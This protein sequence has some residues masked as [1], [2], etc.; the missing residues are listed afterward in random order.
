MQYK[1][2][3]SALL[4]AVVSL[5]TFAGF[6]TGLADTAM[7]AGAASANWKFD[8]GGSGAAGGYT[9]VSASDGYNSSRGYGFAQTGN[10]SN[11]SAGGSGAG[12][13]AVKFNNYGTGNTFNVDLPKGLYEIKVMTGNAPRTTIRIEG[14]VQMMNLTG[15]NAVETIRIPVTD[16]Q[17]NVQAIE[18]MSGREQSISAM[19]VTQINTTCEMKPTIWICGDSTVANYYNCADTSQHGWGQFLGNY[20]DSTYWDVR[21]QATSGQYAK[22]FYDG[23][24]F[25]PIET[26]GKPG[27]IYII[28]IGINDSNYSNKDE[29]RQTVTTMVQKAKAKGMTVLLV[30]QQGRRGDLQRSPLLSGRW[31]GGE[32]DTVGSQQDVQVID[33]FTP[34]QNFGL[35]V[36]YDG[37]AS[38]YAIQANGSNDDLHQSKKGAMKLAEIMSTLY[39]FSGSAGAEMNE[40]VYYAFK[41]VNSGLYLNANEANMDVD[42]QKMT[43]PAREM[44]WSLRSAGD[45]YYSINS[46][47]PVMDLEYL[48]EVDGGNGSNGQNVKLGGY[49]EG[50]VTDQLPAYKDSQLF[51]FKRNSDGSYTIL[52]KVSDDKAAVE[53]GSA[54]KDAGANVQ[55]WET[56][57]HACQ[58]WEVEVVNLPLNGNV[59]SDLVIVDSERAGS[60]SIQNSASGM[61]L[62]GDRDFTVSSLPSVLSDSENIVTACDSKNA[63]GD[64]AKF[65]VKKDST[66]YV[67]LDNRVSVPSWMSSYSNTGESFTC[68][69][70]QF[71]IYAKDFAAGEQIVLGSNGTNY[72]CMNYSVFV[73]A[74]PEVTTTTTTEPPVT[75][76][77][78]EAP[79]YTTTPGSRIVMGD[80]NCDGKFSVADAVAILQSI[81]NKDKYE[82]SAQG[83]INGDVDGV[84]GITA[85]DA[86]FLQQVDAGIKELPDAPEQID[87]TASTTTTTTTTTMTTVI[88]PKLYYAVDQTW[89]DGWAESSNGGFTKTE[90]SMGSSQNV[91][92]VNLNNV[93]GSSMTLNVNV[94]TDGNY[95][96]YI[97]YANGTDT[98]RKTNVFV[99]GNTQTYWLQSFPG[100]GSWT[101]WKGI[102][103]VL[104]LKAGANTIK[105]ESAV[106]DGG[107]NFDYIELTFTDEPVAETFDPNAAQQTVD[108]SKPSLFLAGDSTCMYYNASKQSQNG[109]PIQGWGYYL[110]DYFTDDVTVYNNAIAGRSSKKFY[111]EGRFASITENLKKG[112]FVMIQFAI[113]DADYTKEDRYSPV[114]GNV[115]N[116][117][118][119][120]YEWYLTSFIKDT[121]AKGATPILMSCTLSAKSYSDGKFTASYTN[122]TDA[123]KKLAA[124][125]NIPFVDVNGIMVNHY[126]SVGY[127]KAKSYHMA[128]AVAGSSDLTHFNEGGA[129]VISGLIA[130]AV[131]SQSIA[132]LSGYVK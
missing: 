101:D 5:S 102:G 122:Y 88:L 106:S 4:S 76:T 117:Q 62:F 7:T 20:V 115:D 58:K 128:G 83:K 59:V 130:N 49:G 75:T 96:T 70:E 132:G 90:A 77:T 113:N 1:K 12:S 60:W 110:S 30:K 51:K 120:S 27:D 23:G 25:A 79:A 85:R 50:P 3:V 127:D 87:T 48:L 14:M 26:Y 97:R 81:A 68:N 21:N 66:V 125:Y 36:G 15:N 55:Q 52:T 86:L 2:M 118:S 72:N 103:L 104:P 119:G 40:S 64:E 114:C 46:A 67:A 61:K 65:A 89:D 42:Q 105:F 19:E 92:Y 53:V 107:P 78:T 45:G 34:W 71:L 116:P 80:A 100:T 124:K 73:K 37:M 17:L 24:Q 94:Q 41:N 29:Y 54:S 95:M 10:V 131:K 123:C 47:I 99:N 38:Y 28:A 126:N 56:N 93:V 33:L 112:D 43:D 91:G 111:D 82:L 8:F 32:L 98:D 63:T 109:G 6:G 84:E 31:Y 35:S 44:A 16:G 69:N 108:G 39:D 9:G 129:K 57:G 11:V 22:G 13:D 74:K 121:M 18:G